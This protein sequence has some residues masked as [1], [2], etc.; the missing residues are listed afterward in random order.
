MASW[1]IS[2]GRFWGLHV[3][4]VP[5][6]VALRSLKITIDGYFP[7]F[8][9]ILERIERLGNIP[10]SEKLDEEAWKWGQAAWRHLVFPI[11]IFPGMAILPL[12]AVYP[13]AKL[14]LRSDVLAAARQLESLWPEVQ[15]SWPV[16]VSLSRPLSPTVVY[17]LALVLGVGAAAGCFWLAGL[18]TTGESWRTALYVA[19]GIL[20]FASLVVLIALIMT[21]LGFEVER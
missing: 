3:S 15:A 10:G 4:V 21:I 16:S 2:R 18:E 6:D 11:L 12:L 14:S 9:R 20:G 7:I 1:S 19:G 17:S 8:Q 13:L 5:E